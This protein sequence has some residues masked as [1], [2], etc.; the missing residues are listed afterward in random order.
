M[1]LEKAWQNGEVT[2]GD[3]A[4]SSLLCQEN[5]IFSILYNNVV[6]RWHPQGACLFAMLFLKACI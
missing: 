3:R 4:T 6:K 5:E 1:L 2:E